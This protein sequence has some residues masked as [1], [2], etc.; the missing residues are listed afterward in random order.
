M[1]SIKNEQEYRWS[2]TN[3]NEEKKKKEN[4]N[5]KKKKNILIPQEVERNKTRIKNSNKA[6][7][8]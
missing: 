1:S 5:K 3:S 6:E 4:K 7:K 2:K 8:K